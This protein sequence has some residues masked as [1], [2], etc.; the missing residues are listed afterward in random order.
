[1]VGF[2]ESQ[3][4]SPLFDERG[5]VVGILGDIANPNAQGDMMDPGAFMQA[6]GGGM[7]GYAMLGII[8][9]ERLKPLIAEPPER[10]KK[11]RGWLGVSYQALNKELT[12]YW[13]LDVEGG[14]IL[15]E[16]VKNSPAEQSGAQVGDILIAVNGEALKVFREENV[17]VF[18]R[19]ISELGVGAMAELTVLR[20]SPVGFDTLDL[21]ATLSQAPLTSTE[22]E[23]YE[24]KHFEFK[25]RN[26]VFNDY[27]WYNLDQETFTGVW[28]SE[29]T[30]GGWAELGGLLPRDIVQ[31][32]NGEEVT[33]V[34]EMR[35]AMTAISAERLEEV[36][37][38]VWRDNK[39]LFVNIK[40]NWKDGS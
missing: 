15:N 13:G 40:P 10:G 35:Q 30:P 21:I 22:A 25:V 3:K 8:S 1:V 31:L 16:V 27:L 19:T 26:L 18:G 17:R 7:G 23:T 28:V 14:V 37:F 12:E 2:G 29:V 5:R 6:L 24:D 33:N 11:T 4:N 20:R 39:T 36:V 34:E 9:P 32:V 38:F